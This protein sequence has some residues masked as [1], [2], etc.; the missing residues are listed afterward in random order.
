MKI[1]KSVGAF[2]VNRDGKFLL[3]RTHGRGD[4]Y[5]DINKGGIEKRETLLN[6][7][8]RELK[9]ELGTDKFGK[10]K[11]LN[12]SFTFEFPEEIKRDS[13]K[14]FQRVE[15]FSVEFLGKEDD[16]KV[17]NK[18]IS[19]AIFVDKNEFIKKVSFETTRNA[20]KKFIN[21]I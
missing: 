19:K 21:S 15:L 11:K 18:E 4:V 5:W 17:D 9:E 10:I 7:L 13:G 1:R 14:E 6:A 8:K 12:L 20:F 2:V 16:I 3:V